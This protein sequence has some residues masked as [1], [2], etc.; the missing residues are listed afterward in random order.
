MLGKSE[1]GTAAKGAAPP[2][3]LP[4]TSRSSVPSHGSQ[5]LDDEISHVHAASASSELLPLPASAMRTSAELCQRPVLRLKGEIQRAIS[6]GAAVSGLGGAAEG[7]QRANA[8]KMRSQGPH[9]L[10]PS[11][12]HCSRKSSSALLPATRRSAR[13]ESKVTLRAKEFTTEPAG[14]RLMTDAAAVALRCASATCSSSSTAQ[15]SAVASVYF[16]Q[17]KGASRPLA[18]TASHVADSQV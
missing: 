1:S 12:A 16:R 14:I 17:P 7:Q 15:R 6:T 8:E 3:A 4:K 13:T 9:A 2:P 5:Q 18:S 10:S 11:P